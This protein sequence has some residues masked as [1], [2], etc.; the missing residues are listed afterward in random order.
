MVALEIVSGKSNTNYR[1]REE[2]VYLLDWAYVLQERGHLLELVDPDLG[3]NYSEK[4]ALNMLIVG[5]SCTN[6]SPSLRPAMSSVVKMLEGKAPIQPTPITKRSDDEDYMRFKAFEILSLDSGPDDI[7]TSSSS[8]TPVL[9]S[10]LSI[11]GPYVSSTTSIF[12]ESEIQDPPQTSRL[13]GD[14]YDT[15]TDELH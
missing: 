12:N 13:L 2:F 4:E 15:D 11:E 8:K 7:T 6:L 9:R 1:P 14:L 5:L 3:S 10:S